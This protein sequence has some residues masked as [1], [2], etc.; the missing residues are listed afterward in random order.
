VVSAQSAKTRDGYTGYRHDAVE[1]DV[2]RLDGTWHVQIKP[3]Y[4]FTWDGVKVS[5]HHHSALKGI[6]Q[7][8][9]APAVSQMVRMFEHLFV[10][11]LTLDQ[12]GDALPFSLGPLV[13]VSVPVSIPDSAWRRATPS[14]GA[15]DDSQA[16]M[17]DAEGYAA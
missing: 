14:D 10:E 3:T 17:F 1:L 4:V 8:D 12:S 15:V 9:G 2:R 13:T 5:R 7:L 11:R 16:S 6:K